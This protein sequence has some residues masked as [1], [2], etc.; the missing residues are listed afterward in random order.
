[1][2]LILD[3]LSYCKEMIKKK[4]YG[5]NYVKLKT[6]ILL[7]KYYRFLG[8]DTREIKKKLRQVCRMVDPNYNDTIQGWK[9]DVAV[10]EM[11][12]RR[13]RQSISI[14]ITTEELQKIKELN[15]PALERVAFV[16]LVYGKFLKYND[17]TITKKKVRQIGIFYVN[18]KSQ[19]IFEKAKVIVRKKER[20]EMLHVL[21]EKGM[22]DSTRYGGVV[23][24]YSS[25]NSPTVFMV[26]NYDDVSLYYRMWDK[27]QISKCEC[28]RL[29]VR[30]N[31]NEKLCPV[32]KRERQLEAKR[33]WKREHSA[34]ILVDK[35]NS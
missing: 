29:F 15:N 23:L 33:K 17:T 13:I 27:E 32:C 26:E 25:E 14:P 30:K 9:L 12:K 10:R 35:T 21:Y 19:V 1:M 4:E 20:N 5:T 24:K 2:S 6:L 8:E 31:P 34:K 3:E 22:L 28:G 16:Y 7:A 18:E 11:K